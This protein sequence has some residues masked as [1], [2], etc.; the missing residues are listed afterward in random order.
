MRR[1]MMVM[2]MVIMMMI[3]TD[4]GSRTRRTDCSRMTRLRRCG[5]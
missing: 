3:I 2:M 4:S 5:S 1:M